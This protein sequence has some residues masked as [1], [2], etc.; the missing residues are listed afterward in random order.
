MT[1]KQPE[2]RH[3]K[4]TRRRAKPEGLGRLLIMVVTVGLLV[5]GRG[6]LWW[7]GLALLA[8]ILLAVGRSGRTIWTV[9]SILA[10]LAAL[11]FWHLNMIPVWASLT[12]IAL[13]AIQ[14]ILHW[15]I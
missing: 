11:S 10:V 12:F 13:G 15:L 14:F 5:M 3:R 1:H 6:I 4:V 2:L 7:C 8:S 9:W